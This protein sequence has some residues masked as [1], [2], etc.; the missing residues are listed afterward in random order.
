MVAEQLERLLSQIADWSP[1]QRVD[2]LTA[3]ARIFAQVIDLQEQLDQVEH[4][5]RQ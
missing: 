5:G 4:G 1:E 3:L 2:R